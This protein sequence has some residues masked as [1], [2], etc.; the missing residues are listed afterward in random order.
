MEASR[1]FLRLLHLCYSRIAVRPAKRKDTGLRLS[2]RAKGLLQSHLSLRQHTAPR[3][4]WCD[5]T[6]S[7]AEKN[8][9]AVLLLR[10]IF[11]YGTPPLC[12]LRNNTQQKS[13]PHRRPLTIIPAGPGANASAGMIHIPRVTLDSIQ[14]LMEDDRRLVVIGFRSLW[15]K[16]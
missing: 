13:P 2:P 12:R 6:V 8:H 15:I 14:N 4:V 11:L 1:W 7:R 10:I 9:T 16:V 3:G 5:N